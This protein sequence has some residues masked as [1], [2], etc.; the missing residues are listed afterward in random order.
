MGEE[1]KAVYRRMELLLLFTSWLSFTSSAELIPSFVQEPEST[2][3]STERATILLCDVVPSTARITWLFNGQK[4]NHHESNGISLFGNNLKIDPSKK[5]INDV[6]GDYQCV[7]ES[8][9]GSIVSRPAVLSKTVF[10]FK[11]GR[12]VVI[13]VTEGGSA[14]LPCYSPDITS[15]SFIQ[16]QHSDGNIIDKNTDNTEVLP[17]GNIVLRNIELRQTGLYRCVIVN[18]NTGVNK[19]STFTISLQVF[20]QTSSGV[21]IGTMIL[22]SDSTSSSDLQLKLNKGEDAVLECPAAGYPEPQVNWTKYAGFLPP[23]RSTVISGNLHIKKIQ[24]QDEGTYLCSSN[25]SQKFVTLEVKE[26]PSITVDED[27]IEAERGS[28]LRLRCH[29]KGRPTPEITWYHDGRI[30]T[31]SVTK[32][33][34]HETAK[35]IN[36]VKATD[37]GIYQCMAK[38]E[39]GVSSAAIFLRV[40]G[41]VVDPI[42][43]DGDSIPNVMNTNSPNETTDESIKKH[44]HHKHSKNHGKKDRH[45]NKKKN[46]KNK[47]KNKG[48]NRRKNKNGTVKLVPPSRPS[49]TQLSESSVMLN[50][51]VPE[52]DGLPVT[53][54][55]VQYKEVSPKKRAWQT[56]DRDIAKTVRK[57]EVNNLKKGGTYKFRIAAVYSNNDNNIGQNSPR[58]QLTSNTQPETAVPAEAPTIVEAKPIVFENVYG[59]GVRWQYR[60]PDSPQ[61]EGFNIFYKPYDHPGEYKQN[62][63][64]GASVREYLLKYLKSDTEYSIKMQSYNSAGKSDFSNV[65]VKRT[66]GKPDID[67]VNP[68]PAPEKTTIPRSRPPVA[69]DDG[70]TQSNKKS[71]EMLYMILGIVLG[72]MLLLLIVFM[73]MCWWKQRQQ[74]RMLA[75]N[76]V[77]QSKFQDQAHRIYTDSMRKKYMNGGYPV[78]GLNGYV[79]NGHGPHGQLKPNLNVN[80]VSSEMT[81]LPRNPDSVKYFHNPVGNGSVGT[82]GHTNASDNNCNNINSNKI[83][84]VDPDDPSQPML[85]DS[86]RLENTEHIYQPNCCPN[87]HYHQTLPGHSSNEGDVSGTDTFNGSSPQ[88]GFQRLYRSEDGLSH[89]P[90]VEENLGPSERQSY[91]SLSPSDH[92]SGRYSNKHR[93]RRKQRHNRE[94][95][96]RDQATNTDLS[97]NEGASIEFTTFNKSGSNSDQMNVPSVST[98]DLQCTDLSHLNNQL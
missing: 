17:S 85:S 54:F 45:K 24:L 59:I 73:F 14:T 52:N 30:I 72:I 42:G 28:S 61:I 56:E 1:Y 76:G 39:A 13:N 3:I 19:T 63:L 20:P 6:V 58:F 66:R 88:H 55:R 22:E 68:T 62:N 86:H 75:M 9:V 29:V 97:S 26:I 7:A 25:T 2:V 51:T 57:Y 80:P 36:K 48:K 82:I 32:I 41:Q 93:H 74:R 11:A 94:Q 71:S 40:K 84:L 60:A 5:R 95:T 34:N 15:P 18:P 64:P 50:W 65:V 8:S 83:V 77:I 70:S 49:V 16:F 27:V 47:K 91:D 37:G 38:N 43:A 53:F 21:V 90:F 10:K 35:L 79:A 46:K 44:H 4:L 23:S 92:Q 12:D 67:S 69:S 87:H 78:N 96:T 81:S 33:L 98:S 89:K 31:N